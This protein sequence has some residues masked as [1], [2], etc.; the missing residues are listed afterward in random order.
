MNA[1]SHRNTRFEIVLFQQGP[2]SFGIVCAERG[3][4]GSNIEPLE[5][6][7]SAFTDE[8]MA[9]VHAVLGMLE[10]KYAAV[11][12]AKRA[13]HTPEAVHALVNQ[14]E[15]ARREAEEAERTL[16]K[17]EAMLPDL[18]SEAGAIAARKAADEALL[19]EWMTKREAAKVEATEAARAAE[20]AQAR[21]AAA[22]TARR[23]AAAEMAAAH[24][25]LEEAKAAKAKLDAEISTAKEQLSAKTPA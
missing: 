3:V 5:V 7:E 24:A 14:G 6:H 21:A 8:E 18:I 13:V 1:S 4:H 16:A 2:N 12:D 10:E 23:E 19:A 20:E 25:A 22:E 15:R 9:Q 17:V 11:F